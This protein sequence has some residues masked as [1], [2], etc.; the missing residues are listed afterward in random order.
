[1]KP[2]G[3]DAI[4]LTGYFNYA[5]APAWSPEGQI[6][7]ATETSCR[8]IPFYQYDCVGE[9]LIIKSDRTIYT[10]LS[11]GNTHDPAWRP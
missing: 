11:S 10:L 6:A 8:Y 5:G 3:T 4:R 1:M 2:D 7:F 9:I